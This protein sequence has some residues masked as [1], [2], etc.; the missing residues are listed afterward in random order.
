MATLKSQKK[1]TESERRFKAATRDNSYKKIYERSKR[2]SGK[3]SRKGSR[4]SSLIILRKDSTK[5]LLNSSST[6]T[7]PKF[8]SLNPHES[9]IHSLNHSPT[10]K[11]LL[12]TTTIEYNAQL[13]TRISNLMLQDFTR[14][15]SI[16]LDHKIEKIEDLHQLDPKTLKFELSELILKKVE[17]LMQAIE[18]GT[19]LKWLGS[20][21]TNKANVAERDHFT[22]LKKLFERVKFIVGGSEETII[23]R[24]D[25]RKMSQLFLEVSLIFFIQIDFE[26]LVLLTLDRTQA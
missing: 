6:S 5:K 2:W 17:I 19:L 26:M 23:E 25:L 8:D 1:E 18:E 15:L 10:N 21:A 16:Y 11:T 9:N 3:N 7:L 20:L 14:L 12:F 22:K 24:S 4:K 13:G